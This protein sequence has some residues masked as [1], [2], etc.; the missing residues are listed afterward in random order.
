MIVTRNQKSGTINEVS[1]NSVTIK[2]VEYEFAYNFKNYEGT[3]KPVFSSGNNARVYLDADG[4]IAAAEN[5]STAADSSV[6]LGYILGA[7]AGEGI[8]GVNQVRMY[9]MTSG[10]TGER[11]YEL[12]SNVR[13]DGTVQD[14]KTAIATLQAAATEA[15][16]NKSGKGITLG[17]YAQLIRFTLNTD[18]KIDTIDTVLPNEAV[19]DDDLVQTISFPNTGDANYPASILDKEDENYKEWNG[20]YKFASGNVFTNSKNGTVMGI[21]SNTRV[22]VVPLDNADITA[23]KQYTGTSY[24]NKGSSYR[25]EGYCLN[26]TKIAQYVIVYA[27]EDEAEITANANIAVAG[28]V[29]QTTPTSDLPDLQYQDALSGW[30][31]KT[32]AAIAEKTPLLASEENLF[33]NKITAGE[34]FR[35]A[36]DDK[37]AS[38]TEM[39]FE[40][41]NGKPVLFGNL[42]SGKGI[43]NALDPVANEEDAMDY[44]DYHYDSDTATKTG[45]SNRVIYGTVVTKSEDDDGKNR[46]ITLTNTLVTDECGV[47]TEGALIFNLASS[48]KMFVIDTSETDE[49]K[50]ITEEDKEGGYDYFA[51][52]I[53]AEDEISNKGAVSEATEILA[54]YSGQALKTIFIIKR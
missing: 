52:I 26:A 2:N 53:T 13:I 23:Y 33:Y 36:L 40:I 28:R 47:I 24:F 3:D 41:E 21:N 30:N 42:F 37:Y 8:N 39:I 50:I 1:E 34:I 48:A 43:T 17:S 5:M 29:W 46:A 16:K 31:F 22:L 18:N 54:F 25:V 12:A 27:G 4:K 51:D 10:K 44:R 19:A 38:K 32:G 7:E 35:Y 14:G 20:K 15:N 9:G 49:D 11:N 45:S 6:C